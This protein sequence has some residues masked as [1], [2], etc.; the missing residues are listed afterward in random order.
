MTLDLT[1]DE[2]LAL[3]AELKR[4]IAQDRYPMSPRYFFGVNPKC[5]P[6][7]LEDLKRPGSS[8]AET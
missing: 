1:A 8:I 7:V 3:A 6:T 2:K 4:T 5:A